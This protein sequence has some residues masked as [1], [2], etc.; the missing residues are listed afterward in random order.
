MSL[1]T[2]ECYNC[3]EDVRFKVYDDEREGL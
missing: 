1:V 3:L 2:I